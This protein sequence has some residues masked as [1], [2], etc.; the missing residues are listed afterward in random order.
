MVM[1]GSGVPLG[2]LLPCTCVD[3]TGRTVPG[4]AAPGSSRLAKGAQPMIDV[5]KILCRPLD[6]GMVL[7]G[8]GRQL[9]A[10]ICSNRHNQQQ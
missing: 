5:L 3:R 9:H 6:Q 7:W 2:M 1:K 10:V 8:T 4:S